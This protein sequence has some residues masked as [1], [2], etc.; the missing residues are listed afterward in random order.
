MS[1]RSLKLH[2]RI[3]EYVTPRNEWRRKI[4]AAVKAQQRK[5]AVAYRPSDRL[6]VE[7]R[8]YF[9]KAQAAEIHDIDNRLKDCLDALQGRIG[10]TGTKKKRLLKPI[11]PNDRQIWR[12]VVEKSVTPKQAR[13]FGHLIIREIRK[14]PPQSSVKRRIYSDP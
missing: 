7:V 6:E 2:V 12:A 9:S 8:L 3:P 14:R 10:G 13:G 4:H 5:A 1:K 11:V